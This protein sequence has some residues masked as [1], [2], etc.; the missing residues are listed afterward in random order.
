MEYAAIVSGTYADRVGRLSIGRLA[1]HNDGGPS[2]LRHLRP[3]EWCTVLE[4]R[5]GVLSV[6]R[7]YLLRGNRLT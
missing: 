5:P 3:L 1:R 6:A 7:N 2:S 4:R